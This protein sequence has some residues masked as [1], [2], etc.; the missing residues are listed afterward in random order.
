MKQKQALNGRIFYVYHG[1]LE[2]GESGMISGPI[3]AP[4]F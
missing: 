4:F 1:P 2:E 3:R